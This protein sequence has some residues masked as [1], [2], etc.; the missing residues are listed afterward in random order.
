MILATG[1]QVYNEY[2][3]MEGFLHA[4]DCHR[5]QERVVSPFLSAFSDKEEAENWM[6]GACRFHESE[7]RRVQLLVIDTSKMPHVSMWR[8]EDI[9]QKTNEKLGLLY[10]ELNMRPLQPLSE[11]RAAKSEWLIL[12]RLP[13]SAIAR[14]ISLEEIERSM[15][16]HTFSRM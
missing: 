7:I 2:N 1:M 9:E 12:H 11:Q 6:I 8:V 4:V 16:Q 5:F 15:Y 14:S 10:K 13:L 3:N